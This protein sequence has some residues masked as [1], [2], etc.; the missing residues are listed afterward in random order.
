LAVEGSANL[1]ALRSLRT[2]RALRPLRAISRWQGMK[3][4]KL[5][6]LI[7]TLNQT[8]QQYATE[9]LRSLKV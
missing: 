2:L 9:I 8:L 4:I 7:A 6:L 5:M 3:V 1:T